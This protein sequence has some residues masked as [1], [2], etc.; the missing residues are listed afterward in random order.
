MKKFLIAF[1]VTA[2][3][4]FAPYLH[5]SHAATYQIQSMLYGYKTGF[6]NLNNEAYAG[7]LLTN[8]TTNTIGQTNTVTYVV[9]N[10]FPTLGITPATLMIAYGTNY[11]NGQT[12]AGPIGGGSVYTNITA[13]N[14][15]L[16]SWNPYAY[17]SLGYNTNL[18]FLEYISGYSNVAGNLSVGGWYPVKV[19]CDANGNVNSN[20]NIT[21]T[22]TGDTLYATNTNTYTFYRSTDGKYW[23]TNVTFR[24]IV[25]QN[26]TNAVTVVT[27]PPLSFLTGA[28]F[29]ELGA[30]WNPTNV[31]GAAY[32]GV[33]TNQFLNQ[34]E[35]SQF[36][37]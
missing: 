23:D 14:T 17:Y 21:V 12:N 26:G 18:F 6:G 20:C 33:S 35:F 16:P 15:N 32:P 8:G 36:V 24:F 13:V 27:N 25:T 9:G 31:A 7:F 29:I 1:L 10:N 30:L 37:P 34:L 2:G 5:R 28:R 4:L 11:I 3:L 22:Q 19:N